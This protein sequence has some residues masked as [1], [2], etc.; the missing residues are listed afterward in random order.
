MPKSYE[1]I[2]KG[3]D[4]GNMKHVEINRMASGVSSR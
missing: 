3:F 1:L 2:L 4:G